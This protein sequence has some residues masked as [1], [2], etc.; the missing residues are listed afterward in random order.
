MTLSWTASTVMVTG[1]YSGGLVLFSYCS[2]ATKRTP[3][4]VQ[5]ESLFPWLLSIWLAKGVSLFLAVSKTLGLDSFL[6]FLLFCSSH[7]CICSLTSC[8]NPKLQYCSIPP[9]ETIG[10]VF[11]SCLLIP[12]T[13]ATVGHS[14]CQNN[15]KTNL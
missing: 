5:R 10:I 6:Y 15:R 12:V 8:K 9:T 13:Q 14:Q 3:W 4:M 2:P 11:T 7:S 1:S